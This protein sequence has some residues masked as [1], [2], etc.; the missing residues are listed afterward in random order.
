MKCRIIYSQIASLSYLKLDRDR[1]AF[2]ILNLSLLY[3][4]EIAIQEMNARMKSILQI[5]HK[6]IRF[7]HK[8]ILN[9]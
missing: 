8:S 6:I 3:Q 4:N 5:I 9:Y 2:L 7:L 1:V